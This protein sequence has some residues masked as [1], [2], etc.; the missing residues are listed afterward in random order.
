MA[1]KVNFEKLKDVKTDKKKP[2]SH[3]L[4]F[5]VIFLIV[6][7]VGGGLAT[8]FVCKNDTFELLGQESVSLTVG[9]SYQ[10]EGVKIIAFGKD[11]SNSVSIKTELQKDENGNYTS[12]EEGNFY[13]IYTSTCFKFGKLFKIQKIRYIEFVSA[14]EGGE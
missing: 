12:S 11:E 10:D 4:L 5:A 14:S 9:E 2:K 1:K 8:Y 13:I 7:L 6:G 3:I